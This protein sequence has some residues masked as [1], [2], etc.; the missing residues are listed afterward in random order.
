MNERQALEID[1]LDLVHQAREGSREAFGE[2]VVRHQAAVRALLWRF[3]GNADEVDDIA[4]D[5]FMSALEGVSGFR[6][7]SMFRTWLLTVTRNK[8]MSWLRKR[9]ANPDHNLDRVGQ[10][11]AEQHLSLADRDSSGSPDL[12][13][14]NECI[15]QLDTRHQTLIQK[16]YFDGQ[17]IAM[18]AQESGQAKNT[19]RMRL[20]RIRQALSVC[21]KKKRTSNES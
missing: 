8:A 9:I 13:A 5:V 20:M 10:V 18:V 14:L 7:Q 3:V 17:R 12:D 15:R 4:Q 6:G 11:V 21:I 19:V 16:V 2:L 1:D